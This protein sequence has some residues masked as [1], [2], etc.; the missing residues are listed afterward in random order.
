MTSCII[1]VTAKQV[2]PSW[3]VAMVEM[4]LRSWPHPGDHIRWL[5]SMHKQSLALPNI[6][7]PNYRHNEKTILLSI[8]VPSTAWNWCS[9]LL[10]KL[11]HGSEL[12]GQCLPNE[13]QWVVI[14]H[15]PCRSV[16]HLC[17]IDWLHGI[18][19]VF[20]HRGTI[21]TICVNSVFTNDEKMQ[22]D[23]YVFTI[24]FSTYRVTNP[25][26][27]VHGANMGPSWGLQDPSG[28]YVS[29]MNFAIWECHVNR[30]LIEKPA[31]ITFFNLLHSTQYLLCK[32][33]QNLKNVLNEVLSGNHLKY[34]SRKIMSTL[35]Q[36]HGNYMQFWNWIRTHLLNPM[37]YIRL[38]AKQ[39]LYQNLICITSSHTDNTHI[40]HNLQHNLPINEIWNKQIT[41]AS[42]TLWT[43]YQ[44][45]LLCL[46]W[47]MG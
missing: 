14:F 47:L 36:Q 1:T 31:T 2:Q 16:A 33:L 19:G 12:H 8:W 39:F 35:L 25:V 24:N 38:N 43:R 6:F 9:S 27:K 32:Q 3:T 17:G 45:C 15:P 7:S 41:R 34:N 44:V 20:L 29:P 46:L 37:I 30:R 13:G 21:S 18:G 26:S 40:T 28:P 11:T 5:M 22:I 42:P 4:A 10:V 23:S